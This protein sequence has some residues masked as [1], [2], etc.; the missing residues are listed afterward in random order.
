MSAASPG[1]LNVRLSSSM[2]WSLSLPWDIS[3]GSESTFRRTSVSRRKCSGMA[4]KALSMAEAV[5]CWREKWVG[6][7]ACTSC[8]RSQRARQKISL[9]WNVRAVGSGVCNGVGPS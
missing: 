5:Y 8:V 7:S 9:G 4:R 2:E 6:M 1:A 3:S